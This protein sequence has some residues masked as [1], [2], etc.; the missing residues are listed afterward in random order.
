MARWRTSELAFF[1]SSPTR[2]TSCGSGRMYFG[3]SWRTHG[4][5][6]AEKRHVW[7]LG[8]VHLPRISDMSSA[9]PMSSI[10]S[11]SSSVATRTSSNSSAPRVA[12][13]LTRPGVPTRMSTPRRSS[14]H[15]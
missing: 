14:E 4:G 13:S 2:S 7:R 11:A 12:R 1:E 10:W 8:A 9:K 6:V 5:N 15:C 3:A